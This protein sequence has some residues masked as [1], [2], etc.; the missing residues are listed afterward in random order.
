[1]IGPA[2]PADHSVG[3]RDYSNIKTVILAGGKGVRLDAETIDIPKP[4][5]T[6]GERPILLHVMD[7]FY[8]YGLSDFIVAVGYKGHLIKEYLWRY[9][10]SS[11]TVTFD[12]HKRHME[13]LDKIE[14]WTI[15]VV[16]TGLEAGSAAR[17]KRIREYVGKNTF[18]LSYADVL[19][20]VNVD[21]LLSFHNKNKALVTMTVVRRPSEYGIAHVESTRVKSFIEK[22]LQHD[23]WINAGIFVLDA[24][25]FEAILENS[26]S[27]EGDVL[28]QLS[29]S[30]KVNAYRHEGFWYSMET[31]KDR[32]FLKQLFIERLKEGGPLPWRI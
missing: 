14:P 16:D 5:V 7:H 27:F 30:G 24:A 20:N 26:V 18:L 2:T 19:S 12:F 29:H 17:I 23:T 21:A 32:E 8:D 13:C 6:I 1:M 9:C 22:G 11:S 28:P 10:F 4:L 31:L 15:T 25:I 3:L